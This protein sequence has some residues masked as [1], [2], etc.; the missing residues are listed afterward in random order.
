M[1]I[2]ERITADGE[3]VLQFKQ[4]TSDLRPGER[5]TLLQL[6]QDM[7]LDRLA[8]AGGEGAA[9][10]RLVNDGRFGISSSNLWRKGL[11]ACADA[12]HPAP[13]TEH[14]S[15]R[16]PSGME[17]RR[18]GVARCQP[19]EAGQSVEFLPSADS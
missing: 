5:L 7:Y 8:L 14:Q 1:T 4:K 13:N 12:F 10:L 15:N 2:V 19:Y 3:I 9:I 17:R 11:V 18:G 16:L 6:M